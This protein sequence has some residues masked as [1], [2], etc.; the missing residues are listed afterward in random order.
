MEK[1][2]REI[3]KIKRLM[4]A[5][6][7]DILEISNPLYSDPLQKLIEKNRKKTRRENGFK[8]FGVS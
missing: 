2:K 3:E 6:E 5:S 4:E 1:N 8:G 7:E